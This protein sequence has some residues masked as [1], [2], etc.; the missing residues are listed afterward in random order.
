MA[1]M[2]GMSQAWHLQ[3]IKHGAVA[4]DEYQQVAALQV[5]AGCELAGVPAAPRLDDRH[6]EPRGGQHRPHMPLVDALCPAR[7]R[8]HIVP[9]SGGKTCVFC[10]VAQFAACPHTRYLCGDK[11][12]RCC[13]LKVWHRNEPLGRDW[14]S[15]A[16][17]ELFKSNMARR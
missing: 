1:G 12:M 6:L 9:G 17:P 7:P 5:D 16:A 2:R 10:S 3:R 4:A 11:S 13:L 15:M 8:P 14:L